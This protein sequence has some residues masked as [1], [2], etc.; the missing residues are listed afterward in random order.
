MSEVEY[1]LGHSQAEMRRLI[2]QAGILKPITERLLRE[3]GIRTGMRILDL[4]SGAGDVAMLVAELVGPSGSVVG[5][6]KSADAI[7]LA[8]ERVSAAGHSNIR[9]HL[10]NV[11]DFVD[12]VPFDLA[13]G[14][15][16]L[17]HQANPRAFICSAASVIRRGG[18]I[19]FHEPSISRV[20]KVFPSVELI[21]KCF[22]WII[23]AFVSAGA[24]LNA[25]ENM[26]RHLQAVG[27]KQLRLFCEMPVGGDST[28]PILTWLSSTVR[29]ALPQLKLIDSAIAQ[30]VE[31]ETLEHRLQ[32]AVTV[33]NV[34]VVGP[35]QMCGWARL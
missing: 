28:S 30:E 3:A 6:D 23:A 21:Q 13:I 20:D 27:L 18:A 7:A 12:P 34:Q 31:I 2:L 11:E 1:I 26:G 29:S 24:S 22:D 4:G 5:I 15:Y 25:A 9:F 17:I 8:K 19:A 10:G 16:V 32:E 33:A 14:R 35:A